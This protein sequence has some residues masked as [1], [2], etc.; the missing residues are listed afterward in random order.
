MKRVTAFFLW[1]LVVGAA[2]VLIVFTTQAAPFPPEIPDTQEDIENI[3]WERFINMA[4]QNSTLTAANAV[5]IQCASIFG[6]G[7]FA[8]KSLCHMKL[9]PAICAGALVSPDEVASL[10]E[11]EFNA[12]VELVS[13]CIVAAQLPTIKQVEEMLSV[14]PA[15]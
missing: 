15:T 14:P 4:V 7:V 8:E 2:M 12:F 9:A 10:T 3:N 1:L 13:T 11:A 6:P 5:F